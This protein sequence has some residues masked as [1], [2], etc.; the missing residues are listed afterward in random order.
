MQ[1][2]T[3]HLTTYS[4]FAGYVCPV[5][6]CRAVFAKWS[7]LRRHAPTHPK[8]W[9][10]LAMESVMVAVM[11]LCA[12]LSQC[13]RFVEKHSPERARYVLLCYAV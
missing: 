2:L 8:G 5:E 11:I 7:D 3:P 1:L 12:L 6:E 9:L 13:V 10:P 4:L